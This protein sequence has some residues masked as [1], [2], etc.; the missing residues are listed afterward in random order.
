MRIQSLIHTSTGDD[1]DIHLGSYL[2]N[3]WFAWKAFGPLAPKDRQMDLIEF[4]EYRGDKGGRKDTRQAVAKSKE[5]VRLNSR[6]NAEGFAR[7]ISIGERKDAIMMSIH[8]DNQEEAH[9]QQTLFA[10]TSNRK[11]LMEQI[12]MKQR[13]LQYY[14]HDKAKQSKLLEGI[15]AEIEGLGKINKEIEDLS[16]AKQVSNPLIDNYLAALIPGSAAGKKKVPETVDDSTDNDT[17]A[18]DGTMRFI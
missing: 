13:N 8:K 5:D 18:T 16:K 6:S 1:D 14:D 15:E 4:G 9:R 11:A 7:G 3:G 12:N 2:F 10:L 17:I